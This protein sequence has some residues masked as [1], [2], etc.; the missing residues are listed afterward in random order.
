V[1]VTALA[2]GVTSCTGAGEGEDDPAAEA[3]EAFASAWAA[4]EYARAAARTD[5]P[6]QAEA[7]LTEVG[8]TLRVGEA[9]VRVRG[10]AGGEG[11]DGG[12]EG[13]GSGES[14][15]P[16]AVFRFDAALTLESLGTWEYRGRLPVVEVPASGEQETRWVVDWSPAVVHPEL[17]PATRLSRERSLPARAPVLDRDGRPL[18]EPR[19][20][21]ELGIEPRRLDRPRA[22]YAALRRAVD[23]DTDALA[24]RVDAAEPDVFV[25]VITL[26]ASDWA[27]VREDLVDQP[28]LHVREDTLTLAP[29]STYGRAVLGTV[30]PATAET[31]EAAGP[32]ASSVDDIG[33]SGLQ[34]AYQQRLAGR[35]AGAV[36][37]VKR[38]EETRGTLATLHEFAGREGRPL[39][40]TLDRDVQAA[41]E[42]ALAPVSTPS[43]LV[44]LKASTGEVLAAANGPAGEAYNRAFAGR[45]PPGSTF[46]VVTTAALLEGGLDPDAP[47]P[48]PAEETVDG[49]TFD[50]ADDFA[51]GRVPFATDFA[52]SCNTAF[53]RLSQRLAPDALATQAP[54]FGLGTEWEVGLPAYAGQVPTASS[55]VDLAAS[56]IGQGRVLASPLG[57]AGVAAT[58]ASGRAHPPVLLADRVGAREPGEPLPPRLARDLRSLMRG[59]VADGSAGVLDLPGAPVAAKT[60]TAEYGDADP[61]RTHAWLVGYRGDLAFAVLLE[62][63]GGGGSD[64]APVAARFLRGLG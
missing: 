59:V 51:L 8:E 50:N 40:T 62:D 11:A 31:L 30:R 61:P 4:G 33:T 23:V 10:R 13:G 26:R 58:V 29:T 55:D 9:T 15:E 6:E 16:P 64:A 34:G 39:A 14:G 18:M 52:E 47:V 48:C 12:A 41:A 35:P 36:R 56:A 45:Y 25:P 63:G 22:T 1:V 27:D 38:D 24:E 20:V 32:A 57:M 49:K 17:T 43:A 21:V 5:A 42:Q 28:G 46:K 54:R 3:A 37:L 7:L 2:L 44:A 53:V 19:P 60:G